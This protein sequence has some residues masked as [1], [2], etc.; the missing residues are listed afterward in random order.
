M[1]FILEALETM[2]DE[3]LAEATDA[4][5]EGLNMLLPGCTIVSQTIAITK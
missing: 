3:A 4:L 2:P 5:F 1:W